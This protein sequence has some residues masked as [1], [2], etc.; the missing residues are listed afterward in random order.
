[1]SASTGLLTVSAMLAEHTAT[2][3]ANADVVGFY[4][5]SQTVNSSATTPDQSDPVGECAHFLDAAKPQPGDILALDHEQALGTWPQRVAYAVAWLEECARRTGAR[6]LLY[7]NWDWIKGMRT[8]ATADQWARLT[9]FPLWLAEPTGTPGQ[10]STVTS[11]DGADPDCWPIVVHQYATTDGVDRDYAA[12][13]A[14][15][16]AC[17]V[18]KPATP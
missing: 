10:H 3:R 17:A 18:P 2:A 14:E 4:H 11:Q 9:A 7:V 13:L 16:T 5:W 8:A 1:V 15:L 12:D 6:P